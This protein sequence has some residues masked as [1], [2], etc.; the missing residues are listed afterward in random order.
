MTPREYGALLAQSAPP[1]P[2]AVAEQA[3]RIL[4]AAERERLGSAA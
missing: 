2:D 1:I 4:V 3:A